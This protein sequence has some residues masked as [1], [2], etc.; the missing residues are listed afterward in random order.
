MNEDE[1]LPAL[2]GLVWPDT[3][4][5]ECR[6]AGHA[7]GHLCLTIGGEEALDAL[8]EQLGDWYGE[9]RTLVSEGRA[10]SSVSERTGLP[11]LTPF[12]EDE[13]VVEMRA[14]AFGGRWIGCGAVR[15]GGEARLVVVVAP[16]TAPAPEELPADASWLDRIVAVTGWDAEQVR[17]DP[18][19]LERMHSGR[20]RPVDCAA[21]EA[22]LGTALPSDYKR[23][24]ETF[25]HGAFDGFL[26]VR[27]PAD[28][29]KSAEFA[30]GW[31]K[32]HGLRSW[33]PHPPF[34]EPGGLLPW[35]G[36]EHETS[37]Y[38]ITEGPDPDAWPVYVTEVGPEAGDR[39]D[40]TASEFVFRMLTDPDHPYSIPAD[41]AAHWFMNYNPPR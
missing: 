1:L 12:G 14:W 15:V 25:G 38:W 18:I 34:P 30:A 31:A 27:L 37:F 21:A 17:A 6:A 36:T 3:G 24:V 8:V 35:A 9:P 10:D 41:F 20:I 22:R 4:K 40:M 16:R 5:L 7:P 28:I 2:H 23:L 11:L 29:V 26:D 33:E 32:T 39:F 19:R 13:Q